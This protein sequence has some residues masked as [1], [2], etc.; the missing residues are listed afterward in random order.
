[1]T[2]SA[3]ADLAGSCV[4]CTTAAAGQAAGTPAGRVPQRGR[5]RRASTQ[6][7][8][9]SA[10]A[11][12]ALPVGFG[13][14]FPRGHKTHPL[15]VPSKPDAVGG[16]HGHDVGAN[17]PECR[18][19]DLFLIVQVPLRHDRP[20]EACVRERCRIC[21]LTAGWTTCR[22][23]AARPKCRCYATATKYLGRRSSMVHTI[24]KS[25]GGGDTMGPGRGTGQP[26]RLE[27]A[28]PRSHLPVASK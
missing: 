12:N 22:R 17:R 26:E 20:G 27:G 21:R 18:G 16:V 7:I 5:R 13:A 6:E 28:A 14:G 19:N 1:M 25:A 2:R 3:R 8:G 11:D 4:M 24:Y 9:L 23:S 15:R 10:T